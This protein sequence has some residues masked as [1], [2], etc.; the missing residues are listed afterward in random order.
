MRVFSSICRGGPFVLGTCHYVD[1][2]RVRDFLFR[3]ASSL[4][5]GI[6]RRG[7]RSADVSRRS[8]HF[9]TSFCG[10]DFINLVLS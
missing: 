2:S 9:V 6:M 3:L 4:L 8:Q 7:T 1:Q 10:C 5:V